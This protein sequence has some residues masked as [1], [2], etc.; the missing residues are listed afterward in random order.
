MFLR[1]GKTLLKVVLGSSV[2]FLVL[3]FS[4]VLAQVNAA[5][6]TERSPIPPVRSL[7]TPTSRFRPWTPDWCER[8]GQA[9]PATSPSLPWHLGVTPCKWRRL[10]SNP[11]WS[12][13][14]R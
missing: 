3:V 1:T 5:I 12:G 8:P 2:L 4:V 7:P 10:V 9:E 14:S 11:L 6:F 13:R